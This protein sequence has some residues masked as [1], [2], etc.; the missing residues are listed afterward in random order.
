MASAY[1]T[2]GVKNVSPARATGRGTHGVGG[3]GEEE[4][5][6]SICVIPVHIIVTVYSY[7]RARNMDSICIV[8][9][10]DANARL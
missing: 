3:G 5:V 1:G 4:L 2:K 8:S 7:G 10:A 9:A 6:S